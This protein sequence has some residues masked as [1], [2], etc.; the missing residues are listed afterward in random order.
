MKIFGFLIRLVLV[1]ALVIWLADRPGSAHIVCRD[2]VMDTSAAVLAVMAL[3]LAYAVLLLHKLWR[4]LIDGPYIWSLKRKIGK[5]EDGQKELTKGLAAI[6][7]GQSCEAGRHAVKAR[8]LLGETPVTQLLLA[9]SAQMSGDHRVAKTLFEALTKDPD[10]SMLGY[11]GLI[12]TALR[13]KDYDEV[14]RLSFQ[15][16]ALKGDV[17][18]LHVIRFELATRFENWTQATESLIKA[19][20]EKMLA[21]PVAI[22][23]EAALLLAEAKLAL[24][25]ANPTRALE[26]AEKAKRLMPDWIPATLIL[27]ETQIVTKHERAALRTIERA[28]EKGPNPQLIPLLHWAMEGVGT[29]AHYKQIE[30]M[31]RTTHD[32]LY[33]ALALAEAAL[34]ADLWG[35]SRRHLMGLV[36]RG[37]ATQTAFQML[38][39]LE[40]R[41]AHNEKAAS[42][43]TAR[44]V[45]ATPDA[46]WLCASC[47]AAH[48]YWEATCHACN[49]FN[50]ME[51][52]VPGKGRQAGAS[53][54]SP[55]L[56]DYLS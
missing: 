6:A 23:H 42:V 35:E 22:K 56:L 26:Y 36:N 31:T 5:F 39:R 53:S 15:L 8:K 41:E 18:W 34:K 33:A 7:S 21:A 50:T 40:Q 19:R 44:A 4:T 45:N 9:Q 55:M 24:R 1:V 51:W 28:W 13:A 17:P 10:A 30:R 46:L 47:G 20:K 27:A 25:N 29:L 32:S 11:R 54:A 49:S 52:G 3:A 38:A 12:M 43:W 2:Y 48:E 14:S 16:E 37:E